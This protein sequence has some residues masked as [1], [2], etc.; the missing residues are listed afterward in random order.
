M[1]LSIFLSYCRL[2]HLMDYI[3]GYWSFLSR[4]LPTSALP[5]ALDVT[6]DFY[7][8]TILWSLFFS[9]L[10]IVSPFVFRN[11][12]GKWHT[13]LTARDRKDLPSY[14]V[15][16]IHHLAMVP[17]AWYHIYQD[18]LLSPQ[19]S[20]LADY[21][22]IE[23]SVAPFVIGYLVGDT[24]CYAIPEMFQL[25]FEFM[26]HHVLT[27]YLIFSCLGGPG[28]FCRF[29]PHL[30]VCDTTNILFN[31]AWLLR[32][33]GFKDTS[34]VAVLEVTFSFVFMLV[35]AIN[36]P[37]VFYVVSLHPNI[38]Q[39]GF[40]R[41]TLLPISLM[42]W[43]WFSKIAGTIVTKLTSSSASRKKSS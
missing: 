30:I 34:L 15:C 8:K 20:L 35:R 1:L 14:V 38:D 29:I 39:W 11:L 3:S 42:Q 26:V 4:E 10:H 24:V 40:A 33:C 31:S 16:T 19:L 43:Y 6:P 18:T 2:D 13:S 41:Y 28:Y 17:T 36:L 23:S 37:L 12:F 25:R 21:A 9:I 5:T 22:L 27:L 7:R 32:R